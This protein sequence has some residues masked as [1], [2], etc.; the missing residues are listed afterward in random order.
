MQWWLFDYQRILSQN[1]KTHFIQCQIHHY[2]GCRHW[3]TA[4]P[5]I[6]ALLNAY[7]QNHRWSGRWSVIFTMC[8]FT[9]IQLLYRYFYNTPKITWNPPLTMVR[10]CGALMFSLLLVWTS[11]WTNGLVAG[12]SR[13]YNVTSSAIDW[14]LERHIAYWTY[15]KG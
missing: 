7:L 1:F 5:V 13:S 10:W 3:V 11:W 9:Q 4:S 2:D 15:S 6:V 12:N 8:L 14:N